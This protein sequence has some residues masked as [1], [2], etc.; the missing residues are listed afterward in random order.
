MVKRLAK[1]V[2]QESG[3]PTQFL[4][5]RNG[6]ESG[7]SVLH[8][9]VTNFT[10]LQYGVIFP[11]GVPTGGKNIFNRNFTHMYIHLYQINI[12]VEFF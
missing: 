10:Y 5:S 2:P 4:D 9:V 7:T 3:E 8:F 1:E 6:D 11:R 12:M